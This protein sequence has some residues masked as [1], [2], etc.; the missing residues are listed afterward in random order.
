MAAEVFIFTYIIQSDEFMLFQLLTWSQKHAVSILTVCG[1]CGIL[2][3]TVGL[4]SEHLGFNL[5]SA[6]YLTVA[7]GKS[8]YLSVT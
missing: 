8:L 7:L 4:E 1:V 3:K 2:K 5:Y 6:I